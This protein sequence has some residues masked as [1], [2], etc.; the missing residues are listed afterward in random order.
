MW[1]CGGQVGITLATEDAQMI[2]SGSLAKQGKVRR[3]GRWLSAMILPKRPVEERPGT[4]G[5]A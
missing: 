3:G 4:E 1:S 2:I 5:N